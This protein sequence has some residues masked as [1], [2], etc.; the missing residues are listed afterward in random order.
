M[1]ENLLR[2]YKTLSQKKYVMYTDYILIKNQ[3]IQLSL[4]LLLPKKLTMNNAEF[5]EWAHRLADRMADYHENIEDYPVKSK[6]KPGDII[7][8]LPVSPPLESEAMEEIMSDFESIIM[9]GITHWQSPDFFAY[10]PANGSYPSIL[11]EML[12]ASLGAQCMVW[13]TSP[14]AAELE[15]MMMNW[16]KTMTGLPSDWHGVIQDTASTSTLAAILCAREKM[17]NYSVNNSGFSGNEKLRV[18]C[19]TETHS[20]V[21]KAVKIAGIGL[22]NLVKISTDAQYRLDPILLRKAIADDITAGY[23]PLCIVATLG[24]TGCTSVDPLNEIADICED[25]GIWLHVDAAYAGTALLLPEYRWMIEGIT[26]AD[27]FVFNPHK[28]M[29]TNFDCSAYFIK[30]KEVLLRTFEILPE[31]LKTGNRGL[32]ND[33]RDWGIPLGRRFRALKLWFVIRSYGVKQLM[34]KIREHIRIAKWLEQQVIA[35]TGFE[36]MAPVP[37][38]LVCF[39]YRPSCVI[40]TETLNRVNEELLGKLNATGRIFLT[41]TKL[42]GQ[43]TLRMSIAGTHTTQLHVEKAWELIK[44]TASGCNGY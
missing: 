1:H 21:E 41:H 4:F 12:T 18:Y 9:P 27:S 25:S 5:R 43:Y 42:K 39:R 23:R 24:T 17:M 15:E 26:K 33:Y 11:A 20:S 36:I 29:F 32:V 2:L 40:G 19:S 14:A 35:T 44:E 13:D 28:W 10:F 16:L 3:P 34:E 8:Q 38:S 37:L 22:N 7:A 31:Y 6:S 30:D